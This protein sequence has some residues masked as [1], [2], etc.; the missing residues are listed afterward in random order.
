MYFPIDW[1]INQFKRP[2]FKYFNWRFRN[3]TDDP[4]GVNKHSAPARQLT[5]RLVILKYRH[6]LD[7]IQ[8]HRKYLICLFT[9]LFVYFFFFFIIAFSQ[10]NGSRH[11]EING[12]NSL[13]FPVS[14]L[15][16][17]C[18]LRSLGTRLVAVV[19]VTNAST[20]V[21][22]IC[23]RYSKVRSLHIYHHISNFT[24]KCQD[25]TIIIVKML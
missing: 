22:N 6:W 13:C 16:T 19:V 7:K 14:L 21:P 8:V 3:L 24:K 1:Y 5:Q 12:V 17:A 10:R 11:L 23:L 18:H 25:M 9:F 4:V 20:N 2:K 15:L